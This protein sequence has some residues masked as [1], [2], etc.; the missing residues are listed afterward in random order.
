[1]PQK[2]IVKN[3]IGVYPF[4][5]EPRKNQDGSLGKYS[6]CCILKKDDPQIEQIKRAIVTVAKEKFQ[7]SHRYGCQRKV[8]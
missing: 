8:R 6:L 7:A 5:T 1:M 3:V 4:L 2:M